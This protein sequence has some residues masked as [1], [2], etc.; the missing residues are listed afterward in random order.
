MFFSTSRGLQFSMIAF[1]LHSW[2]F[3]CFFLSFAKGLISI[4]PRGFLFFVSLGDFLNTFGL[5]SN[6]F[7]VSI[8]VSFLKE[9]V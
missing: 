4:F 8:N 6:K 3:S 2:G 9:L 7:L 1:N 5:T